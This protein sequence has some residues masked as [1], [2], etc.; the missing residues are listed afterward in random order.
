L[1]RE[2]EKEKGQILNKFADIIW[3]D[4]MSLNKKRELTNIAKYICRILRKR[5]TIAEIILWEI[6]RNRRF[7]NIKFYR[8][9]PL[10]Y[11]ITGKESF[12][13]ADFY[14]YEMKLVIELDGRHHQYKLKA[15]N[16]R[17]LIIKCLG[18]SV[19]RFNN[20]DI[21]YRL[22]IVKKKLENIILKNIKH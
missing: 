20:D 5:S 12:F 9:Y 16:E 4:Y 18:I 6:I 7:H 3:G 10:F 11:D 19:I 1:K 2:G 15:D 22:N 13:V 21:I 14:S 17:T 8:Q